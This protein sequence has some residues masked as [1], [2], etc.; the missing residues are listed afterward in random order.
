MASGTSKARGAQVT[1][2]RTAPSAGARLRLLRGLAVRNRRLD[3]RGVSTCLL[4]AGDGPDL[5]LLH[6]GV[7]S[8]GVYWARLLPY[9]SHHH[10]V[11]P[12]VPGFGESAPLARLELGT[13]TDWLD[14]LLDATSRGR[15]TLVAHSMLGS[16]VA[17]YAVRRGERLQR[18]VLTGVPAI[19]P[20]RMPT[21][22]AVAA[23]RSA[24]WP[25]ASNFDRFAAWPFHDG[26]RTAE[27][28]PGWF[29][30]FAAYRLSCGQ[31]PHV[32]RAMRQAIS[33]GRVHI[34]DA[35]LERITTPTALV[36][37]RHDRMVPLDLADA[38]SARLGWPLTVVDHAGHLPFVE[39]P[40]AFL[41][42]LF[43]WSVDAGL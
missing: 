9:L 26:V 30:A 32:R 13:F 40:A 36:W 4:E 35:A 1:W 10:V 3:L 7:E 37:G 18:L 38:A 17:R 12:D 2:R 39:E 31:V 23:I 16:L 8:G 19:G 25:S 14:S 15:P 20:Y 33:V 43:S 11:A 27:S 5:V 28:D 24:V 21:N 29:A 34:P 22:L 6:G 42:A 41:A